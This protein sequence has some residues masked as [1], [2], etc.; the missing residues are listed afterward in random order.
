MHDHEVGEVQERHVQS[1]SGTF[2]MRLD[3]AWLNCQTKH[4]QGIPSTTII[5]GQ[6]GRRLLT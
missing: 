1:T 5:V 6:C 2:V 4:S 3:D